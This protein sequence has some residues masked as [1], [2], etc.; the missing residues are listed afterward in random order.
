MIKKNS[1]LLEYLSKTLIYLS[2]ADGMIHSKE[3]KFIN[4]VT[5]IFKIPK[6]DLNIIMAHYVVNVV[7]QKIDPYHKFIVLSN[8]KLNKLKKTMANVIS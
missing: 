4:K 8:A 7:N 6:H 5:K 1:K 2:I 3:E